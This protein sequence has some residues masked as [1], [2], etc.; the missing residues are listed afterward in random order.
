MK[1]ILS[2]EE[3]KKIYVI[4]G[5]VIFLAVMA[6]LFYL[7]FTDKEFLVGLISSYGYL[8]I[9]IASILANATIILPLPLDAVIFV[10]AGALGSIESALFLGF[11]VG[12]GSAIGE[13]S[14]YI[15][16]LMGI[17]AVEKIIKKEIQKMEEI[18]KQL[19]SSGMIFIFLGALTPFPFDLIGIA[20]GVIRYDP[21]KFFFAAALGKILRYVIIALA[22]MY[23]LDL[24]KYVFFIG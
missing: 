6:G 9:F 21:K 5:I 4:L 17:K 8:G 1:L 14:A 16:G 3:R 11:I 19:K 15:L 24:I 20:A 7:Y 18:Q 13:M 23:G 10:L 12:F 22:G 2:V